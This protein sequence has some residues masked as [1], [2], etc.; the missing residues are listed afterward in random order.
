MPMVVPPCLP[1]SAKTRGAAAIAV[2]AGPVFSMVR[3][4]LSI[5][6]VVLDHVHGRGTTERVVR[7]GVG[8][9]KAHLRRAHHDDFT[10]QMVGTLRFAHPTIPFHGPARDAAIFRGCSAAFIVN[11]S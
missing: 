2:T 11:P 5:I 1:C 8:W 3:L 7:R 4:I 9:A 6:G 10:M